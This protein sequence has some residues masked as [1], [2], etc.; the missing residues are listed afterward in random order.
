M[1]TL[2]ELTNPYKV[3]QKIVALTLYS[4][5]RPHILARLV[6]FVKKKFSYMKKV[7]TKLFVVKMPV[8]AW[9][10]RTEYT[11]GKTVKGGSQGHET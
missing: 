6:S 1:L 4:F 2:I 3:T 10:F 8:I 9:N 7:A 5:L 11:I